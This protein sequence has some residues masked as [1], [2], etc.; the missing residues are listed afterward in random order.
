MAKERY[1]G[2]RSIFSATYKAYDS[3]DERMKNKPDDMDLVEWHYL[4][5]YFGSEAFQVFLFY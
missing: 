5:L 4:I 1:K 3:Y 2:W